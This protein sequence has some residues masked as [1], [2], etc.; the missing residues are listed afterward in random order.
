M[1][2]HLWEALTAIGTIALAGNASC[3]FTVRFSPTT[4]GGNSGTITIVDNGST[5]PEVETLSGTGIGLS[6]SE[7]ISNGQRIL[8]GESVH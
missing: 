8:N 1:C 5:S 3:T 2:S 4:A 6:Q 7:S